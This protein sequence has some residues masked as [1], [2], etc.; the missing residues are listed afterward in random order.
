MNNTPDDLVRR[1]EAAQADQQWDVLL[2]LA[3]PN[4]TGYWNGRQIATNASELRRWYAF[5]FSRA[6]SYHI[7]K[8]LRAASGDTVA[9]EW[10]DHWTDGESTRFVDGHGAEFWQLSDGRIQEWRAYW[11]GYWYAAPPPAGELPEGAALRRSGDVRESSADKETLDVVDRM[12]ADSFPAS[13]PPANATFLGAPK[14]PPSDSSKGQ[15]DIT[16]IER[17]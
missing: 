4:V 13:D 2:D 5:N 10:V 11:H 14:K 6:R 8:T 9:I 3:G 1:S 15:A 17:W 12:S 7:E 16:S